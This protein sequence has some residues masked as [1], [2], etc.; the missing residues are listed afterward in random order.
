MS[1][2]YEKL[3]IDTGLELPPLQPV[4]LDE[5]NHQT[6]NLDAV[7]TIQ[8]AHE[9]Y[10]EGLYMSTSGGNESALMF[11][12]VEESGLASDIDVVMID[13][14]FLF[15][16]T[17]Y[18]KDELAARYG[19]R[20]HVFGPNRWELQIATGLVE[21]N[22]EEE[23]GPEVYARNVE[24]YNRLTKLNPMRRAVK[25]LGITALLSGV[26]AH[27]TEHRASL[28]KV[29]DGKFGEFRVHPVLE[30]SEQQAN[31]YFLE[32]KLPRHPLYYQGYY[33]IGDWPLT[34]SGDSREESRA[35]LGQRLECRL[36]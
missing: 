33:S 36:N 1:L 31:Q 11:D 19:N 10:S 27:Q 5:A 25:F 9:Q 28:R 17:R 6:K 8:W 22:F 12:L 4:G 29:D 7:E 32:K 13:T 18:F 23:K 24:R 20:F 3:T 14:E 26:R 16:S 21:K 2:T 34:Q 35:A 30:W 15:G